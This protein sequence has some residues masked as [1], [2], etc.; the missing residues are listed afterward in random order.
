MKK[1]KKGRKLARRYGGVRRRHGHSYAQG[2]ASVPVRVH[3][4]LYISPE[5]IAGAVVDMIEQAPQLVEAIA[6]E[7]AP[8]VEQEVHDY[9][10][11]GSYG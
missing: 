7:V 6:E 1:R 5:P 2:A 10:P 3:G 4:T 11:A 9:W 8:V